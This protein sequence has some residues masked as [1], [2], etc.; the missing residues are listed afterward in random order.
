M[1]YA[2]REWIVLLESRTYVDHR[3]NL[4][5]GRTLRDRVA[6][7]LHDTD[8]KTDWEKHMA[9]SAQLLMELWPESRSLDSPDTA[10]ELTV[11]GNLFIPPRTFFE[12]IS[13]LYIWSKMTKY[14]SWEGWDVN[15]SEDV[16]VF[17]FFKGQLICHWLLCDFE[18]NYN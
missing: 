17:F 13:H 14:L 4:R 9:V 6:Q 16:F 2:F 7:Q 8:K 1:I 3:K 5:T 18:L 12:N 15:V 11:K 10:L